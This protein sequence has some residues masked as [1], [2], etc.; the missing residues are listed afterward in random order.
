MISGTHWWDALT[1]I[2]AL[3]LPANRRRTGTQRCGTYLAREPQRMP[4]FLVTGHSKRGSTPL[5]RT[6]M[7]GPLTTANPF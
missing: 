6:T 4:Y 5:S 3:D 2:G 7:Y 1:V